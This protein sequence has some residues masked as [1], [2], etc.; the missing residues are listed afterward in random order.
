MKNKKVEKSVFIDLLRIVT[1]SY[2]RA[3]TTPSNYVKGFI[4]GGELR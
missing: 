3:R 4:V 1:V 2:S